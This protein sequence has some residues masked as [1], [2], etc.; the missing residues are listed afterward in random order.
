[1]SRTSGA[2]ARGGLAA[3]ALVGLFFGAGASPGVAQGADPH[4][5]GRPPLE[6]KLERHA[7]RLGLD[8]ETRAGIREIA[9]AARGESEALGEEIQAL[10]SELHRLLAAR[11]PDVPRIMELAD[12]LGEKK[13]ELRKH[14]LRTMLRIRALLTPEQRAELVEIHRERHRSRGSAEEPA[15]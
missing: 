3:A 6:E 13:T 15:P 9:L 4:R 12:R 2:G 14:R 7:A 11:E 8:A 10:R 1:V 5:R